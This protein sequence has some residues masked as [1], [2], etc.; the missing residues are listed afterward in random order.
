M[1]LWDPTIDYEDVRGC[2]CDCDV[3]DAWVSTGSAVRGRWAERWANAGNAADIITT[4]SHGITGYYKKLTVTTTYNV[5]DDESNP[6]GTCDV[7]VTTT[8]TGD[9]YIDSVPDPDSEVDDQCAGLAPG[10]YKEFKESTLEAESELTEAG[11]VSAV[12]SAADGSD[13]V[14]V[15]FIP[16]SEQGSGI[17]VDMPYARAI[18]LSYKRS[19]GFDLG[20]VDSIV[21]SPLDEFIIPKVVVREYRLDDGS[22]ESFLSEDVTW[23]GHIIFDEENWHDLPMEEEEFWDFEVHPQHFNFRKLFTVDYAPIP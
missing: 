20:D 21:E 10:W 11:L 6:Q 23:N 12:S 13:W 8:Y 1:S 9:D 15:D 2:G 14:Q 16:G 4:P 22:V 3:P 7:V 17:A 18:R 19:C 5:F